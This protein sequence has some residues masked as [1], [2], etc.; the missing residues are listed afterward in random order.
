MVESKR[1]LDRAESV[2][3]VHFA[4][5]APGTYDSEAWPNPP[6]MFSAFATT[7]IEH[8]ALHQV[9]FIACS[10]RILLT[11]RQNSWS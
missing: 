6:K 2:G 7:L 5:S 9:Y 3:I 1:A 8:K 4:A 10:K 11:A